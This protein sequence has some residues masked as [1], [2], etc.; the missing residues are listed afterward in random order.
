MNSSFFKVIALWNKITYGE[1]LKTLPIKN[2]TLHVCF[3]IGF[4]ILLILSF[5]KMGT[6]W[7]CYFTLLFSLSLL[8]NVLLDQYSGSYLRSMRKWIDYNERIYRD[9]EVVQVWEW[10]PKIIMTHLRLFILLIVYVFL[11]II[12]LCL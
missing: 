6:L 5:I 12:F 9:K 8:W 11:G 2:V 7:G 10:I 3:S 4:Y 1:V